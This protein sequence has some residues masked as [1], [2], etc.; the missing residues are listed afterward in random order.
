MSFAKNFPLSSRVKMQI[1][2][3]IF[4]LF[5]NVNFLGVNN[6]YNPSSA[7]FNTG[8]AATATVISSATV[9]GTFGQASRARD[10]RQMQFGI[11]LL[12]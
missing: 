5:N 6:Y 8:D 12:W 1:R 3:D 11:K 10:P 9:P 2:W 7:T 4:N